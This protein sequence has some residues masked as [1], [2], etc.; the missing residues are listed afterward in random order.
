MEMINKVIQEIGKIAKYVKQ[1]EFLTYKVIVI[2]SKGKNLLT[3][4]ISGAFKFENE[5]SREEAKQLVS[6]IDFYQTDKKLIG[7]LKSMLVGLKDLE[8]G[9]KIMPND[10]ITIYIH[11][12]SPSSNKELINTI[13]TKKEILKFVEEVNIIL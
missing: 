11:G 12:N 5:L 6:E 4:A 13:F 8:K 7:R 2:P 9:I 3:R 10:S 1:N